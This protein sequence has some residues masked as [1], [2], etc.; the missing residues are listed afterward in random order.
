MNAL[1][2][3]IVKNITREG[4]G[5]LEEVLTERSIQCNI[6]NLD[7][8]EKF[9]DTKDYGALVV[10]GGPDSANDATPKMQQ[11][12]QRIADAT[13]VG[14][15]YLGI[16]LGLQTLVK[17]NGGSVLKSPVREIGFMDHTGN[18]FQVTL[19]EAGKHDPLFAGMADTFTV[20]HLHGETV[21]LPATMK[22]Q[23]QLLGTGEFCTNQIVK[24]SEKGYGLQCHFELTPDM[25][26]EWITQD[27][28]LLELDAAKLR[29]QFTAIQS[30]YTTVGKK[31]FNNFLSIAGY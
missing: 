1:P 20:F 21:E 30:R 12:L 29:A 6:V 8:G 4:P 10:L 2:I 25:F 9:P 7:A 14:L 31:L 13:Q 17:A 5:L 22:F 3:L 15:P 19:T 26:E 23:A 24:V 18:P 11:E 28:D 27:P 16:C